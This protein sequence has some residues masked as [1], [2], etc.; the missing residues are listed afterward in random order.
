MA[1]TTSGAQSLWLDTAP[2]THYPQLTGDIEVDVAVIGGGI[3][4]LTAARELHRDGARVAVLEAARVGSGVTGCTTAKVSALQSTIYT[5]IRNRHGNATAASYA[6]ASVAGVEQLATI[7]AQESIECA[8]ERRPAFTYAAEESDRSEVQREAGAAAQAGLAVQLVDAA[9]LPFPVHGAVRLD[10]QL[11]L[12]P[13]RYVQGLAAAI[14]GNGSYIFEQSRALGVDEGQ[15]CRV[16]TADGEVRAEHVVVATHYPFLDRGL[17]FARFTAQRSYCIAVRLKAGAPPQGMSISA[18]RPTHSIRSDGDLLIVGGEGHSAGAGE[19]T[20]ERF[21]RLEEF[22][23]THWDVASVTHRWSAQDP[24]HYDH[25]PVIGPYR[26]GSSRLW[27]ASGFMK[28]GLATSTFAGQ[29]LADGIA[30]RHNPWAGTFS[31]NRLSP[32]SLHEVA[33]LGTRFAVDMVGDRIRPLGARAAHDIPAGEARVLPDGLGRKGVF[34]DDD[35]ALHAVSV[36]CTHLGCL[37]RFNSAER[38]WD[39]PCHGSRFDVDGGVLE[40]PAVHPLERRDA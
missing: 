34:R 20:P 7:V 32:R 38:S 24:V 18:G 37:L 35:G 2:S 28:W 27:V 11:Q 31:P 33:Q 36:R 16:R 8:L 17:Y 13:V 26:P 29:V 9:D 12:H 14:D 5:T 22:A 1:E 19:A 39:C 3:A 4:G 30:G 15:P 21:A 40:G 10:E 6:E 25:L 23:R